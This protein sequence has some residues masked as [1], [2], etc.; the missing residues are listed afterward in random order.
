M[1]EFFKNEGCSFLFLYALE[2]I[3][4]E[5]ETNTNF[6]KKM[7]RKILLEYVSKAK[8]TIINNKYK[9]TLMPILKSKNPNSNLI[10]F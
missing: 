4:N 3:E 5:I 10:F 1:E 2:Y 7:C 9:N 6:D 8:S